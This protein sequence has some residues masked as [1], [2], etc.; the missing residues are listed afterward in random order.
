[1]ILS[2]GFIRSAFLRC[3]DL[4]PWTVKPC[5]AVRTKLSGDPTT[6]Q[7]VGMVRSVITLWLHSHR[8]H[9]RK[10]RCRGDVMEYV[11]RR[12]REAFTVSGSN[13][14]RSSPVRQRIAIFRDFHARDP[15]LLA[16]L[17]PAPAHP[18]NR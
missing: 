10:M 7:Y 13:S 15:V 4:K 17:T 2:P 5:S 3:R 8:L 16:Y 6:I 18:A 11:T 9:A 12:P 1:M 14:C